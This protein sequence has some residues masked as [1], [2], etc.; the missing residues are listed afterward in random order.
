VELIPGEWLGFAYAIRIAEERGAT[1]IHIQPRLTDPT[2]K[3]DVRPDVYG[4][5]PGTVPIIVEIE[6]STGEKFKI[7][8]VRH[9]ESKLVGKAEFVF[10][11]LPGATGCR[12]RLREWFG[13][14]VEL[15]NLTE[16]IEKYGNVGIATVGNDPA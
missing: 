5:R 11:L 4:E 16:L 2:V 9:R 7:N 12:K 10:I 13:P 3:G 15:L 1:R 6:Y 14:S 8:G